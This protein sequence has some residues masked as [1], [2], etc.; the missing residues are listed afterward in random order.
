MKSLFFLSR[1]NFCVYLFSF[2]VLGSF[3]IVQK[4][5]T[6]TDFC[7]GYADCTEKAGTTCGQDTSCLETELKPCEALLAECTAQVSALGASGS[8]GASKNY[9]L[10]D[11][12]SKSGLPN[13]GSGISIGI[14]VGKI[15]QGVLSLVA[16]IFFALMIYGGFLWMTSRGDAKQVGTAKELLTQAIIGVVIISTAWAITTFII[17]RLS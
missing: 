12:A 10:D 5:Y 4:G 14:I 17:E 8:S 15:I 16:L 2:V 9:G 7:P 1:M 11:T 6:A 13:S 3:F